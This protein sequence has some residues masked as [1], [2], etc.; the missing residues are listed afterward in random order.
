[1]T[2]LAILCDLFV[3]VTVSGRL[4]WLSDLQPSGDEKVT[5]QNVPMIVFS[6]VDSHMLHV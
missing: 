6:V 4:N 1:M 3:V 5:Y 2:C